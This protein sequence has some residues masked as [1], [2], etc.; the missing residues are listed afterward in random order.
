[1]WA[2]ASSPRRQ[3]DASSD[4]GSDVAEHEGDS[5]LLS[6]DVF[7]RSFSSRVSRPLM[8]HVHILSPLPKTLTQTIDLTRCEL[9]PI[10]CRT[11]ASKTKT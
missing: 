7:G 8:A 5:D 6:P 11:L 4:D 2:S 9:W 3:P 1:M 10:P